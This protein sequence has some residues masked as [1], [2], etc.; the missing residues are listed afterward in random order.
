MQK[1]GINDNRIS[2]ILNKTNMMERSLESIEDIKNV[3]L[4]KPD[5]KMIDLFLENER[6]RS[7]L[8]LREAIGK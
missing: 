6:V 1:Q 4:N 2:E 3:N 7:E 5:E 8:Y